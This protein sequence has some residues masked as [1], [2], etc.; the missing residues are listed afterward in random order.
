MDRRAFLVK[1]LQDTAQAAAGQGGGTAPGGA[2]GHGAA[3]TPD[4]GVPPQ[5]RDRSRS[6]SGLL[7][8]ACVACTRA[9]SH[10]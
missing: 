9:A 5:V 8:W 10:S 4:A 2:A 7:R 3:G 1:L 6:F